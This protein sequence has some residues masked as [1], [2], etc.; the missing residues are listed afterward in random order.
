MVCSASPSARGLVLNELAPGVSF[1][2]V[3]SL[4]GTRLSVPAGGIMCWGA[5][6]DV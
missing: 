4:T 6:T 3:Q 1:D 5:P 2:A